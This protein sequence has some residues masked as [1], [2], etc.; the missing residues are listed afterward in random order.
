MDASNLRKRE[1]LKSNL[2]LKWF[3]VIYFLYILYIFIN[4]LQY[5]AKNDLLL[6]HMLDLEIYQQICH[7]P[8]TMIRFDLPNDCLFHALLQKYNFR[9][10]FL[11]VTRRDSMLT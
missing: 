3:T 10:F 6:Q 5:F 7:F 4:T 8:R 1:T 2:A 9:Y 11:I